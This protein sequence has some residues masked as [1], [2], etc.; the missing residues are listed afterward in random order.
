MSPWNAVIRLKTGISLQDRRSRI[1][2]ALGQQRAR[3]GV[4]A[5]PSAWPDPQ[6]MHQEGALTS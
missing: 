5:L 1:V 2:G 6:G 4:P 3:E